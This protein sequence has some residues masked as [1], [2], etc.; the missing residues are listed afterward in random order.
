MGFDKLL[1][2]LGGW[3]VIKHTIDAF[4]ICPDISEIIVITNDER[5]KA[6]ER[7]EHLRLHGPT[8][9]AFTFRHRFD[10]ERPT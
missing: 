8:P 2:P 10:V 7:L 9:L 4:E 6:I 5:L 1:A 3:P